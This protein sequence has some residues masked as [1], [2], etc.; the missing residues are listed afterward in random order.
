MV[1]RSNHDNKGAS[2]IPIIDRRISSPKKYVKRYG[3]ETNSDYKEWTNNYSNQK[4]RILPTPSMNFTQASHI[5]EIDSPSKNSQ[6]R[7]VKRA[8]FK[9]FKILVKKNR[10]Y[11]HEAFLCCYITNLK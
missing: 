11:N 9:K 7:G 3:G 8:P 1:G 6:K 5:S 4:R 10:K 2:P